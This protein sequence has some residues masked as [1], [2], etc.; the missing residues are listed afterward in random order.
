MVGDLFNT[1]DKQM[2][3]LKRNQWFLNVLVL[4]A[5][6]AFWPGMGWL[7]SNVEIPGPVVRLAH[8]TVLTTQ[9]MWNG[10]YNAVYGTR[11]AAGSLNV[12]VSDDILYSETTNTSVDT[13]A[14]HTGA[15]DV[16]AIRFLAVT[17]PS[18]ALVYDSPA[19]STGAVLMNRIGSAVTGTYVSAEYNPPLRFSNGVYVDQAGDATHLGV[20]IIDSRP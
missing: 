9:E 6:V 5:I 12:T 20:I 1:E 15:T 8:A 13:R 17:A 14:F 2:K 4:L 10:V 19:T 3:R 18:Y 16:T 11:T 7:T